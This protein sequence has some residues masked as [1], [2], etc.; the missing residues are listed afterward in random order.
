MKSP[1][2][3]AL[4]Q[5][6]FLGLMLAVC[7]SAIGA[8][9]KVTFVVRTYDLPDEEA[10]SIAGNH[11]RLGYW[12]PNAVP[13]ERV[14]RRIWQTTIG[15]EEGTALEYKFTLGAWDREAM[16]PNGTVPPNAT[17]VVQEDTTI[18]VLVYRWRRPALFFKQRFTG[19]IAT[20]REMPGDGILPRDVMVWMPPSY[21]TNDAKRYPVVYVQDGQQVFD[22]AISTHGVDWGL[23]ETAQRLA[24]SEWIYEPIIVAIN[25]T[26]DRWEEYGQTPK[27]AAYRRF[28]VERL[29]PF[30]D[31]NFRTLADPEHTAAMGAS[32]GAVVSFLLVW[33]HTNVFSAAACL[34]PPFSPQE[35]R[36]VESAM[37]SEKSI[38]VYMDNGSLGLEKR[39]QPALDRMLEALQAKGFQQGTNLG[40]LRD[41]MGEH[42]EVSWSKRI[43]VPLLFLFATDPKTWQDSLTPIPTPMY[44]AKDAQPLTE[45]DTEPLWLAGYDVLCRPDSAPEQMRQ[46]WVKLEGQLAALD[47]GGQRQRIAVVREEAVR[48]RRYF[49]GVRW[50]KARPLPAG[51]SSM[52]LPARRMAFVQHEGSFDSL[53]ASLDYLF[54]WWSPRSRRAVENEAVIYFNG[55]VPID[56]PS[57]TADVGAPLK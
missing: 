21:Y 13:L 14:N 23:D 48:S 27:G 19:Q 41:V 36:L 1:R 24:T 54:R 49:V 28:I 22:P 44:A 51:F 39:L 33:E 29:K 42:S 38:R 2:R 37:P 34:S 50:E 5:Q 55:P 45:R 46:A 9:H 57:L 31:S 56:A 17:L 26:R 3:P 32:M 53:E 7:C 6:A 40:W 20:F 4:L 11:D 15:F 52:E 12:E 47:P 18:E 30:I 35:V 8:E 25:N 16:Q 10:V 43:Q